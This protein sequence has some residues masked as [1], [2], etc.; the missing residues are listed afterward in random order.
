MPVLLRNLQRNVTL[1]PRRVTRAANAM[2]A[3]AGIP[4]AELSLML[5]SD[6]RMRRLNA[7]YRRKD[8]P[9]D[10]LAFPLHNGLGRGRGG[11]IARDEVLK[12]ERVGLLG[13]VVISV[14]TARRQAQELG[15]SLYAEV[16][17][18]LI[19]G[20]VHLLGYDHERGPRE[21]ARMARRERLILRQLPIR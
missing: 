7:R 17:R 20:F 4:H 1:N 2:L 19:H 11:T 9:T 12:R 6:Q 10:V 13:D 16:V 8:R 3:A 14:P 18:L 21:A 15:H 5:V